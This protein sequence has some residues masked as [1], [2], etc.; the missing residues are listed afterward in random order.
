MFKIT[1]TRFLLILGVGAL[2]YLFYS[3]QAQAQI[4]FPPVKLNSTSVV[5]PCIPLW[6]IDTSPEGSSLETGITNA[7]AGLEI[8]VRTNNT[9]GWLDEYS[10]SGSTINAITGT[11]GTFETPDANDAHF[12]EVAS[13]AGCYQLIL[14]N[15]TWS[16]ASA[17]TVEILIRDVSS[18]TFADQWVIIDLNVADLDDIADSVWD[19]ACGSPTAST[20]REQLCTDVDDILLA[21]ETEGVVICGDCV[22]ADVLAASAGTELAQ[23]FADHVVEDQGATFDLECAISTILAYAAG[24]WSQ[25]GSVVT[26]QDP[27]GNENRV[28]GTIASPGFN[29]VTITCP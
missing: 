24:E 3:Q 12:E 13:G 8:K 1:L 28:V 25:A 27:G 4:Q 5:L 15:T 18:P 29:T 23:A 17:K 19:E 2:G 21:V 10:Q 6:Q 22:D 16:V 11:I 14:D 26:Y 9:D 7:T 20:V